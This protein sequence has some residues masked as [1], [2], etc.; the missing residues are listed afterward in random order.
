MGC[1]G[2]LLHFYGF[3]EIAYF[4]TSQFTVLHNGK[5]IARLNLEL[6]IIIEV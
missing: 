6:I 1:I 3:I 5:R 4:V 2:I